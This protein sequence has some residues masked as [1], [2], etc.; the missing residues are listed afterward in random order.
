MGRRYVGY[1]V[2]AV[3]LGRQQWM[4][5][6]QVVAAQNAQINKELFLNA[7]ES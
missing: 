6:Q 1:A 7:K 3:I 2:L 4:Q 5:E